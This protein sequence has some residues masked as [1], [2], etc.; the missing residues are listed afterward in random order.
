VYSY[1]ERVKAVRLYTEFDQRASAAIR[2][3]GYPT[4]RTLREWHKE[5]LEAGDLHEAY[6]K[7]SRYS[8]QHKQEA[9]DYYLSHGQNIS[10]TRKALGYPCRGTLRT[11]IDELAPGVRS[12]PIR[13]GPAWGIQLTVYKNPN[14]GV[15]ARLTRPA[16][17][18]CR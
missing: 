15:W 12:V 7:K 1:E 14:C 6:A 11:W 3:L 16:G 8:E 18:P 17:P 10:G 2:A 4:R 13:S 9:V 5:L